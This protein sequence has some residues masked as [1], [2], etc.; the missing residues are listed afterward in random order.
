[1]TAEIAVLNKLAVTLAADSAVTLQVGGNEK[2]YNSADKIFEVS[3][4]DPIAL[5][6][7]NSLEINGMPIEVISKTYRDNHC[8]SNQPSVLKFSE[9]FLVYLER[10]NTPKDTINENI[11]WSIAPFLHELK[12]LYNNSITN[13]I[14]EIVREKTKPE[15]IPDVLNEKVR[16]LLETHLESIK[17]IPSLEW[18][19]S[20]SSTDVLE[21]HGDIIEQAIDS[22][23]QDDDLISEF[24]PLIKEISAQ[25]LLRSTNS[26]RVTGL[27]FAGFGKDE[28]FPKLI[29]YEVYGIVAGKLKYRK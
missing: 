28:I 13:A 23:F 9:D 3:S 5:M 22:I 20:L 16:Q 19:Q 7:Y 1:M 12:E 18:S 29:S 24:K 6:V 21:H 2:I 8:T 11:F 27:V 26:D 10:M 25:I 17:Q 15:T 14:Q 4:K